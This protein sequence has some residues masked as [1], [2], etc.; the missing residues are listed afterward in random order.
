MIGVLTLGLA[1]LSLIGLGNM[2]NSNI[3]AGT[4]LDSGGIG[5]VMKILS[6]AILSVLLAA[7]FFVISLVQSIYYSI[8]LI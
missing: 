7:P 1:G 2:W 8:K 4:S 5:F 6:F 3:F